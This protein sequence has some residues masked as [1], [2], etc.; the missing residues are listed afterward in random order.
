MNLTIA[1]GLIYEI[2]MNNDD[3]SNDNRETFCEKSSN[4]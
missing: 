2:E 3:T 4:E 1:K